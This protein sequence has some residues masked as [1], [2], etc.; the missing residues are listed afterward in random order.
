M[1][2]QPGAELTG[3]QMA[4]VLRALADAAAYRRALAA[5]GCERCDT[6]P[7]GVCPEHFADFE[8]AETYDTLARELAAPPPEP[9]E[10]MT[11]REVAYLFGVTSN[12]V[13]RWARSGRLT[14]IHDENGRPRYRRPEVEA[15]HR[16]GPGRRS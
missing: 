11:R 10:L 5:A 9:A 4:T 8:T 13:A 14:E 6:T 16:S 12:L 2:V 7:D 15:L 3:P 1:T